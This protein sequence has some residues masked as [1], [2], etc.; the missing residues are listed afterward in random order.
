MPQSLQKCFDENNH[1][2]K[3]WRWDG[4]SKCIY[5]YRQIDRKHFRFSTG[6]LSPS[7]KIPTSLLSK[8]VREAN[9]EI[10]KR[11]KSEQRELT[12]KPLLR[13]I[14]TKIVKRYE[15]KPNPEGKKNHSLNTV[16]NC[17]SKLESYWGTKFPDDISAE[18]WDRFLDW[19]DLKYPGFNSFN[20]TKYMRILRNECIETGHLKLKP[21]IIDRNAKV[22]KAKRKEKKD[23]VYSD[24]EIIR[25]EMG[26]ETDLERIVLRLG[27]QNAFR[28]TDALSIQWSKLSL[29]KKIPTYKFS[30]EDKEETTNAVPLS[31]DLV[32]LLKTYPKVKES[33]YVFPQK[34]NPG[35]PLAS[36]QFDFEAIKARGKVTRGTFHSLRHY[37]LSNDFK[38][39][40]FTAAQVCIIRRITLATAQEHYIHTDDR[41]MELLRNAGSLNFKVSSQ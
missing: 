30:G 17:F 26:C 11:L 16:R 31:D 32:E 34:T 4:V 27:Y 15:A 13:E 22:Q 9:S 5:H 8:A 36:Q 35:K 29:N 40:A 18:N 21:K 41:D 6:V 3:G 33:L 19:W 2:L 24:E 28:I 7:N 23:W 25:L 38:N 14:I 20:V 12:V 39:P 37:R 10:S 1:E